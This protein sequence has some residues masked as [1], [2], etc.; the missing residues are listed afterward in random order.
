MPYK[1]SSNSK[2]VTNSNDSYSSNLKV[3]INNNE[4]AVVL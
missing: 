1:S 2:I 4:S 3:K